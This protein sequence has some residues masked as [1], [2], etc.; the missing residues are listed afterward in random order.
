MIIM[1]HHRGNIIG[2]D[3]SG[4]Y[5]ALIISSPLSQGLEPPKHDRKPFVIPPYPS[6]ARSGIRITGIKDHHDW[7]VKMDT[8]A[9]HGDM[10]QLKKET[11]EKLRLEIKHKEA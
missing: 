7:P 11:T 9:Y 10:E 6:E 3:T 8:R 2:L 1:G 5:H 4:R